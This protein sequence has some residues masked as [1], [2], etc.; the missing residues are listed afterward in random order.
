MWGGSQW[1]IYDANG[2]RIQLANNERY[3]SVEDQ[4]DADTGIG[5]F[6]LND[7]N[8]EPLEFKYIAFDGGDDSSYSLKPMSS[9]DI[10]SGEL[11][12]SGEPVLMATLDDAMPEL[13]D[14]VEVGLDLSDLLEGA[15]GDSL[16]TLVNYIHV[17]EEGGNLLLSLNHAGEGIDAGIDQ[18]MTIENMTFSDLGLDVGSD[19]AE[20]LAALLENGVI[21]VD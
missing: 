7:S 9:A 16:D 12:M 4:V 6:Y 17:A 5:H 14:E 13:D 11:S 3:F 18:V 20:L 10:G 21:Y 2:D 8:G 15:S 19:Q 1:S